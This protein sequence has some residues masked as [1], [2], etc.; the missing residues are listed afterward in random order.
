MKNDKIFYTIMVG[1]LLAAA[2][3]IYLGLSA[4]QP[5]PAPDPDPLATENKPE[6]NMNN[7][8][9]QAVLSLAQELSTSTAVKMETTYGPIELELYPQTPITTANFI[10]LARKGYY[11][12]VLFHRVIEGFMIQ[13]GDPNTREGE[14]YTFGSGGPGYR[15]P[16]EFVP[17]LS[18]QPGTIAMANAGPDTGGSQFFINTVDNSRLDNR[19]TVFGEVTAGLD[20]V[21][22]IEQ[23]T[24]DSNDLPL[25]PA[26]ILSIELLD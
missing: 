26:E 20:T 23:T 21:K 7:D 12:G 24:T 8:I 18:N 16:D 9:P 3:F 2:V 19:H 4:D 1:F 17:E 22:A 15:I 11:D 6:N 5:S 13:G 25:E 14:V 10:H